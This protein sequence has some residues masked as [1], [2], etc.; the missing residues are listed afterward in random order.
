MSVNGPFRPK[1]ADL[2]EARLLIRTRYPDLDPDRTLIS[3]CWERRLRATTRGR[4]FLPRLDGPP[5]SAWDILGLFEA[6]PRHVQFLRADLDALWPDPKIE[7]TKVKNKGGRPPRW[8]WEGA[9]I[10]VMRVANT[11][12]GLPSG[13]G[14]QAE[15]E[16]IMRDWF[17]AS[18]DEAPSTSD[19]PDYGETHKGRKLVSVPFR[20]T[21]KTRLPSF[22]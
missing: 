20:P 4:P 1:Y 8:D 15:I 3:A 9:L 2:K 22:A 7:S 16:R 19:M 13:R 21:W 12:D 11:P 17:V 10:E 6:D 18:S 14:A 5:E